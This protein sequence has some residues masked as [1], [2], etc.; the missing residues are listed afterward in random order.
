MDFLTT[1]QAASLLNCGDYDVRRAVDALGLS[2]GRL[3]LNQLIAKDRLEKV[4][5]YLEARQL[6]R[7]PR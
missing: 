4:R 5:R 1:G 7:T 3:G 6:T 2:V